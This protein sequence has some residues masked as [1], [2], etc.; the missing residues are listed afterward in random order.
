LLAKGFNVPQRAIDALRE[1][2]ADMDKESTADTSSAARP[3]E[4]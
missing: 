2:Q 1:E 3:D 4:R